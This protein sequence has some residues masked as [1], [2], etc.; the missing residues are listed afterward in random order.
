[1][2]SI[3]LVALSLVSFFLI[4]SNL[5][6]LYGSVKQMHGLL[7]PWMILHVAAILGTLV[8]CSVKFHSLSLVG[9]RSL[10]IL[11]ILIQ[12]Y[13]FALVFLY[14]QELKV[15]TDIR[16]AQDD[17]NVDT[18][19]EGKTPNEC[20]IDL[21]LE[22]KADETFSQLALR[23]QESDGSKPIPDEVIILDDHLGGADQPD[24]KIIP[25]RTIASKSS[26]HLNQG[27]QGAAAATVAEPLL[28]PAKSEP[29]I[30]N[31]FIDNNF[32]PFRSKN[33]AQSGPKM[34]VFLPNKNSFDDDED[35]DDDD[36][37]SASS[38]ASSSPVKE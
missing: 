10:L 20:L 5:L 38:T 36:S 27:E 18:E 14:Y 1:M 3:P 33:A 19:A 26:A 11:G 13:F 4:F 30:S 25:R 8:F 32:S 31:G 7:L 22:E 6:M 15:S 24:T 17:L 35:D 16:A 34:K 23:N 28:P 2:F 21:E 37:S 29:K 9:Y 12:V